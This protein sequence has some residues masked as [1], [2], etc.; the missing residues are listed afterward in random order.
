MVWVS[1]LGAAV[2]RYG[3]IVVFSSWY[4]M[5]L[6]FTFSRYLVITENRRGLEWPHAE[7]RIRAGG[8]GGPIFGRGS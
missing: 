7:P 5:A 4:V 3:G 1:I 8:I 6:W 2:G